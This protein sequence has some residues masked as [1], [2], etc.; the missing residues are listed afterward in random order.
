MSAA[1]SVAVG[2]SGARNHIRRTRCQRRKNQE[3]ADLPP[4]NIR[5]IIT[6]EAR[7]QSRKSAFGEQVDQP[8]DEGKPASQKPDR[9][10]NV[11]PVRSGES[12]GPEHVAQHLA[13]SISGRS[14]HAAANSP[15]EDTALPLGR[16]G[17]FVRLS[18]QSC[19]AS[20]TFYLISTRRPLP[21]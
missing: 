9:A 21:D 3:S 20:L 12:K 15:G 17:M 2:R 11:E 7:Q 4:S 8:V 5:S 10:A 1:R 13:V 6:I 19:V 16:D 18:N 14:D